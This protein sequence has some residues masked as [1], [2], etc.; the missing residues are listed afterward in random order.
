MT[1][2]DFI[3]YARGFLFITG[4][5]ASLIAIIVVFR[6]WRGKWLSP[7]RNLAVTG[8]A[9]AKK[10][11]P[12]VLKQFEDKELAPKGTLKTWTEVVSEEFY[13]IHSLKK[14]SKEG[15]AIL[16]ESGIDKTID[17]NQDALIS[18]ME[19]SK[20]ETAREVESL[21]FYVLIDKYDEEIMKPIKSYL[22]DNPDMSW[23]SVLLIG[24]Y[25]LR[26]E[27]LKKHEE[28]LK[29]DQQDSDKEE[30]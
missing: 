18:E 25:Y 26:D 8:N 6:A 1:Y 14:L 27:Y 29:Q 30:S 7:I 3:Y 22:F 4:G 15:Q 9:F 19:T 13:K 24:S 17:E 11:L 21:A 16:Q 23:G 2:A 5:I 12:G 28:I 20:P 10:I